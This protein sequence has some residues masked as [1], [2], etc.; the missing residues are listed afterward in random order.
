VNTYPSGPVENLRF[1]DME[2]E[3]VSA[4]TIED[5]VNWTFADTV[6]K[7]QDRSKVT[8]KNSR[9]VKGLPG[10]ETSEKP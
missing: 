3:A 9:G 2:I 1:D 10:F 5:A 4:G 6:L 8:L 7:I